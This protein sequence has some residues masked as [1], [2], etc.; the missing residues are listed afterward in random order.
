Y[1]TQWHTIE[2]VL[3]G[4]RV[5]LIEKTGFGKSLCYQ[6]PA[7]Q[8]SGTTV[9]FSPLIA[10]MRDQVKKLN[11]LKIPA[12][13]IN[14][15]QADGENQSIIEQAKQGKIKILYIAPERQENTDWIEATRQMNLS[16]VVV[17]EAHC[18]SVWGHD[19]R[20]AFRRIINLVNLLPSH[21]PVLA[22]TAT[23]TKRVEEDI[24]KQM[25]GNTHCVRGN[26]LRDNFHLRVVKVNSED[27]KLAWLGA[28][29][30]KIPGN[31]IIYTGT[32]INT[33]IYSRWFEYLGISS[34]AYNAGLEGEVRKEI[35]EG[36]LNNRWKCVISTN[37]LGMGIDKPD[38]RFIIHT[39]IPASPI[40]YYQEIGRA[41]RDGQ[42]TYLILFFTPE[43][44]DLPKAF[45]DTSRPSL[46]KY[47]RV[48]GALKKEPLGERELMR[49]TNLK[50]TQV[51][52]I[53]A[54][55][56]EQ[57]IIREVSYGKQRKYEYQ[58]NAP[59]LNTG[60]F[61]DLR[62]SK[63]KD[64]D[65]MLQYIETKECRMSFLQ[66]FL[67]DVHI[68]PCG[69]CDNDVKKSI[70]VYYTQKWK[71]KVEAFHN[72]YFPLVEV[73]DTKINL[74]NGVASSYYGATNVG[75]L[76]HKCK[77]ENGGD[78]PD[79]LLKQTLRA[80]RKQFGKE[81][82]DLILYVPP[83]ESGDLVKHFAGKIATAL[84]IPLSH[85]LKKIKHTRPQKVFQNYL[86]KYDNV[87]GAFAYTKPSEIIGKSILLI[88]DIYDSGASIKEIGKLLTHLGAVKIGPLI[89]AKTVGGDL[90]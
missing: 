66:D 2:N 86:L 36:L 30:S 27:E 82:F 10:L 79:A 84:N 47:E 70:K 1:D 75:S 17:D 23:A 90:Q 7:T 12:Q 51:R 81:K 59:K 76:I 14:S 28:T 46:E 58:F 6:F 18:I 80:F 31:G 5:L 77:Y 72:T 89:I 22:T 38:I 49:V 13:C 55:L 48:I 32:R 53:R 57:T 15:E 87:A 52:V 4:K 45:I 25:G 54:D 64:L 40:H 35:E 65:K 56:L 43:D 3:Q 19:F 24:V 9:I 78:F 71:E 69:K 33:E 85:N 16:M 20:P 74:V 29:I 37:A 88:D 21:F 61:E 67:G 73:E 60:S 41:G 26:L 83:T 34:V 11:A 63:L 42:P 44:I 62:S 50:Q 68:K 39:Q 8:L